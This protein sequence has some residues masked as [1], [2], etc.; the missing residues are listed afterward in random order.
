MR[1]LWMIMAFIFLFTGIGFA[2]LNHSPVNFDY[3]FGQL[4][5]PLS[6]L[7]VFALTSGFLLGLF[8][9]SIKL[10]KIRCENSRLSCQARASKRE[11]ENLRSMAITDGH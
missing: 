8:A 4:S 3:F 10:F 7:L 11:L 2:L 9:F 6:L 1:I 5:I